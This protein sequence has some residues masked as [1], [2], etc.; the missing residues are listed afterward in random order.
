MFAG[1][2]RYFCRRSVSSD[3]EEATAFERQRQTDKLAENCLLQGCAAAFREAKQTQM[4]STGARCA[5][6]TPLAAEWADEIRE[7]A[8]YQV[9][10]DDACTGDY[11]STA[12]EFAM[13]VVVGAP[14]IS[15]VTV[16]ATGGYQETVTKGVVLSVT[17]K[18]VR[19]DWQQ[20]VCLSQV[21][22]LGPW[23]WRLAPIPQPFSNA[24]VP[25]A[26]PSGISS[27][28]EQRQG[29]CPFDGWV[30]RRGLHAQ[31]EV[32]AIALL[33]ERALVQTLQTLRTQRHMLH[34]SG[35]QLMVQADSSRQAFWIERVCA[36]DYL[37]VRVVETILG[38]VYTC[39]GDSTKLEGQNLS[40]FL[41]T[42]ES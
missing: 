24:A 5:E 13:G 18:E 28:E 9:W 22:G 21:F 34:V 20:R 30:K 33:E 41:K 11:L 25:P 39:T 7:P 37:P 8:V 19:V 36:P 16:N 26:P 4:G 1:M 35:R 23:D 27:F 12:L 10:D 31:L 2:K 3:S 38:L 42:M 14:V 32:G 15:F 6:H 40:S 17:Q 29:A